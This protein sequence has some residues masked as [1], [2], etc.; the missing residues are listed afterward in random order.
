MKEIQKNSFLLYQHNNYTKVKRIFRGV[1]YIVYFYKD[2]AQA[3]TR[4]E[5]SRRKC[6]KGICTFD[7]QENF[8]PLSCLFHCRCENNQVLWQN[9]SLIGVG[10]DSLANS[11]KQRKRQMERE[12]GGGNEWQREEDKIF[13]YIRFGQVSTYFV[14]ALGYSAAVGAAQ[15]CMFRAVNTSSENCRPCCSCNDL[16][17]QLVDGATPMDIVHYR[18]IIIVMLSH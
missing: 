11:E 2:N 16:K 14:V 13:A 6:S 9:G 4:R 18:T 1:E 3:L 10:T 15:C 17:W 5:K 8:V 12:R 7:F